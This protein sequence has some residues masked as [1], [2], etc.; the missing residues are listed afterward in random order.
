M[1]LSIVSPEDDALSIETCWGVCK[2]LEYWILVHVYT[3]HSI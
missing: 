1:F 3:Y 2:K